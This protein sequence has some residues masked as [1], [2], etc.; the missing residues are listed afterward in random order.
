MKAIPL[1]DAPALAALTRRTAAIGSA[2]ALLAIA[3]ALTAF[4]SGRHPGTH[5]LVPLH[6]RGDTIVVVDVSASI[7]TD[8]Y[9]Q[10]GATLSALGRSGGRLGLV[11]FSDQAYEAMPQGTPARDL[12]PIARLFVLRPG[13]GGFAPTIPPNPWTAT[14]SGGTK[15]SAGLTLA[16]T[17][18]TT[19]PGPPSPVV[20]VSDLS[21]DPGDLARLGSVLLAYRRDHV[22]VRIVGLNPADA[23]VAFFRHA[24]SP[25]PAV[26]SAPPAP[27]TASITQTPFP[28]L[29]VLSALL[30]C[31]AVAAY[32]GWS[33]R[34]DWSDA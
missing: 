17:L 22:P 29:L 32:Q 28:W 12:L 3:A 33:P 34:L 23:D 27:A 30:A 20:L 8:S 11:L 16:H 13:R 21:D 15:I 9:A 26:V 31:A 7:S 5:T 24:L 6:S 2:L 10:I 1:T 25:A 14:F 4:L 19:S 18:A